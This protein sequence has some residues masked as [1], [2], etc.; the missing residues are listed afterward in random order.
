[1]SATLARPGAP[2]NPFCTRFHAPGALEFLFQAERGAAS[3]EELYARSAQHGFRGQI[4]GPHG[5][6]KTTLLNRLEAEFEARGHV[7][8]RVTLRDGQRHMPKGWISPLSTGSQRQGLPVPP[9]ILFLDGAE[10]LSRP[11]W[12]YVR[13][14]CRRLKLGLMA[15]THGTL[16]LPDLYRTGVDEK[17]AEDLAARVLAQSPALPRL[18]AAHEARA[19]L[20][21]AQGDMREALFRMYDWYEARWSGNAGW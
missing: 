11:A 17:L 9:S 21:A 1:M 3:A 10:Q 6:G 2:A 14:R 20:A 8:L 12:W 4:S 5:T 16:G 15:T 19:A 13:W 7:V 18:V